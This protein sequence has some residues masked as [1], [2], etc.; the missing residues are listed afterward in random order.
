MP[1]QAD[2]E[3]CSGCFSFIA[4]FVVVVGVLSWVLSPNVI[5]YFESFAGSFSLVYDRTG[6][7]LSGIRRFILD[8]R[9]PPLASN[10]IFGTGI[11]ITLIGANIMG[12]Y[13]KGTKWF[14]KKIDSL[15]N[16]LDYS[17]ISNVVFHL[18]AFALYIGFFLLLLTLFL[19]TITQHHSPFLFIDIGRSVFAIILLLV[20]GVVILVLAILS[21]FLLFLVMAFVLDV[22]LSISALLTK[23]NHFQSLGIL[24]ILLGILERLYDSDITMFRI[25]L[26]IFLLFL[27][28]PILFKI[29]KHRYS[30]LKNKVKDV[31]RSALSFPA[32][33]AVTLFL[34]FSVVTTFPW[35]AFSMWHHFEKVE[36]ED[37][38]ETP[39]K[40]TTGLTIEDMAFGT[41]TSGFLRRPKMKK[42][43]TAKEAIVQNIFALAIK[44]EGK[45]K[46]FGI[47]IDV[48]GKRSAGEKEYLD[49]YESAYHGN[50]DYTVIGLPVDHLKDFRELEVF[51][52]I[53]LDYK[54]F[55]YG[56]YKGEERWLPFH[57]TRIVEKT[58]PYSN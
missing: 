5:Q 11:A 38:L 23:D 21:V 2:N 42:I 28:A 10:I 37:A 29:G 18:C 56:I 32:A 12:F 50:L 15:N 13:S 53:I 46:K 47:C 4:V 51:D 33:I 30:V 44:T 26:G 14:N 20:L 34:I 31:L 39:I 45:V 8:F 41:M 55:P 19:H 6:Q 35:I 58:I 24:I 43:K 16:G 22:F 3:G 52:Y 36:W 7:V 48:Y 54:I 57:Y 25:G 1:R 49:S 27:F 17:D 9:I 40:T